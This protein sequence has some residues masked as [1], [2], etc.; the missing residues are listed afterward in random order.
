M[1]NK[2]RYNF[3]ANEALNASGVFSL[4]SGEY[5]IRCWENR[6]YPLAETTGRNYNVFLYEICVHENDEATP[7]RYTSDEY[8]N[9]RCSIYN[10]VSGR[11]D[12]TNAGDCWCILK[13]Y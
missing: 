1:E 4:R 5:L 10:E 13:V 6:Y 8:G 12:R 9:M 11:P 7:F 2:L 3:H